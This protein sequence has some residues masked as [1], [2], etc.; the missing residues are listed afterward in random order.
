MKWKRINRHHYNFKG[1]KY[2]AVIF[3][4]SSNKK[5]WWYGVPY[6]SADLKQASGKNYAKNY[7]RIMLERIETQ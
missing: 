2:T 5:I 1:E 3:R 4:D 6:A 7:A